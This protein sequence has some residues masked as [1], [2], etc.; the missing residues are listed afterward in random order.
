MLLNR[1]ILAPAASENQ[2]TVVQNLF[3][4]D[5]WDE[6]K[7]RGWI[8]TVK[9][10]EATKRKQILS[11]RAWKTALIT[12]EHVSDFPYIVAAISLCV[13]V[14]ING[15]MNI[16]CYI[17]HPIMTKSD[18]CSNEFTNMIFLSLDF[19]LGQFVSFSDANYILDHGDAM[20][21]A[22]LKTKSQYHTK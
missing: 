6:G 3:D 5:C 22:I 4:V 18:V 2:L 14:V 19:Q 13:T 17:T 9:G 21:G 20:F 8:Y 10:R 7:A 16:D 1:L 11:T 15:N 12:E